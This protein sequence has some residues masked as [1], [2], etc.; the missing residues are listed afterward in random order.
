MKNILEKLE[1]RPLVFDGAFGT[2]LYSKG[3]FINRCFEEICLTNP[4]LISEIHHE[5][6]S[7]GADII[8]TNSFGANRIKL[9][10]FGLTDKVV[11][12]NKKAVQ[13]AKK[14][15]ADH[16]V[17]VAGSV[18]PCLNSGQL[19][20]KNNIE[21]LNLAFKE[22]ISTLADAGTD[23]IL[24]ETFSN[25]DELNIAIEHAN[26]TK[27]PI[28]A[29]F[30]VNDSGE[31]ILGSK[32][33]KIVAKLDADNRVDII[34]LNCGAGPSPLYNAVERALP[35]TDKP[36]IVMPNA[37][38]P[39]EIDGRMMYLVNP[40]YFTE[41]AKKFVQ[42][43]VR[44]IGGC[45]GTT[46]KHILSTAK[47]VHSLSGV[48]KHIEIKAVSPKELKVDACTMAEKSPFGKKL[49]SGEKVT[50]VEI[51]PPRSLNLNP[52]LEKVQ[53][54]KDAGIDA[55]NIP[56]GPRA[57][58]RISPMITSIAIKE[59]IGIEPVL[60]YCC[61]DRNLIGMQS[62]F[63]GGCAAGINNF[64]IITGDPPKIG[65]YPDVTGVFDVD[66]IGLTQMA[67]NLN[68]GIDIGGNPINPPANILIGVGVNPCALDMKTELERFQQKIDAGAEYAITQPVFDSEDIIKFLEKI[69][70]FPKTIPIVAGIWPLT[71]FK[72]A[73]FMKNEVPGVE[74]PDSIIE[75]MSKCK[76]KEDGLKTGIEIAKNIKEDIAKN[77]AGFQVS[78]PFG[79]VELALEIL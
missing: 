6:I 47:A 46:P 66:S 33:E 17:L 62:D 11:E 3:I 9:K 52:M 5:Y 65:D 63:L 39:K 76:T 64:L 48:K 23:C 68:H 78:A 18:G 12:I 19:L 67:Y 74:I 58:A 40:E 14:A 38:M 53:K 32:V 77:V 4:E 10:G 27:L 79:K 30:T 72:N 44:G 24:L 34:G 49:A 35:L 57:S 42:L 7:A 29:S 26:T 13:L 56:D 54:C 50:S 59:K 1:E 43:G 16:D 28:I 20:K 22:C 15:A 55:I 21:N 8:G 71:S 61:R 37:G 75:L 25:I 51:L 2:V 41:Y 60:H 70:A 45:C 69:N 31:T 36:F 73:E